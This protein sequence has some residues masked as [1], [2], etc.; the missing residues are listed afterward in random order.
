MIFL[1]VDITL[2]AFLIKHIS[3]SVPKKFDT[4]NFILPFSIG[5]LNIH[6]KVELLIFVSLASEI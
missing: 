3:H 6:P 1:K 2:Y 5:V 4:L